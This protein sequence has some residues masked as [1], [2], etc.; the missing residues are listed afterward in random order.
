MRKSVAFVLVA[1]LVGVTL[2][3]FGAGE[4][5][6]IEFSKKAMISGVEVEPG[7]YDLVLNGDNV[8]EIYD[9]KTLV[10]KAEIAIE[11]LGARIP[12]SVSQTSDGIVRE[13]R[14]KTE[15]VVFAKS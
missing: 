5:H 3:C 11:P 13:I 7:R 15:R 1:L 9:G 12:N 10:V 2:P 6:R 14:L 8:A 4:T